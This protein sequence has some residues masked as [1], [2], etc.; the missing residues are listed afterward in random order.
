MRK[1]IL[2]I[3]L[4]ILLLICYK[5]NFL[6]YKNATNIDTNNVNATDI[7]EIQTN[8]QFKIDTPHSPLILLQTSQN[9][10]KGISVKTENSNNNRIILSACIANTIPNILC[11]NIENNIEPNKEYLLKLSYNKNKQLVVTI[12]GSQKLD[13]KTLSFVPEISKIIYPENQQ[14]LSLS[15][16]NEDISVKKLT[17]LGNI[18][19]GTQYR[20][21]I[22]EIIY[23]LLILMVLIIPATIVGTK[24][25][26]KIL[27]ISNLNKF[28]IIACSFFIG[29]TFAISSYLLIATESK[30]SFMAF[31][32]TLCILV[33]L[34][35]KDIVS[36]I[37]EKNKTINYKIIFSFIC[38]FVVIFFIRMYEFRE[39]IP[40]VWGFAGSLHSGR[41]VNIATFIFNNNVIPSISQNFGQSILTVMT[42]YMGSLNPY[43]ILNLW[44]TTIS[45]MLVFLV[46]GFIGLYTKSLRNKIAGTIVILFTHPA[47]SLTFMLVWDSGSP[48]IYNVYSDS[49][50][51]LA[52]ILIF[53]L[54]LQNSNKTFSIIHSILFIFSLS[55]YWVV[56][57][58]QTLIL[59]ICGLLGMIFIYYLSKLL[60]K[61]KTNKLQN[62]LNVTQIVI[63]NKKYL[64]IIFIIFTGS[65]LFSHYNFGM[66]MSAD[67]PKNNIEGTMQAPASLTLDIGHMIHRLPEWTGY[68]F[69]SITKNAIVNSKPYNIIWDIESSLWDSFRLMF[70][71]WV[72]TILMFFYL[73]KTK[74][75]K[76]NLTTMPNEN[77]VLTTVSIE[78]I[79]ILF[80]FSS[81]IFVTSFI[82]S[83]IFSPKWELTRFLYIGIF[84]TSILLIIAVIKLGFD[85]KYLTWFIFV[86]III[87]T[88]H[89]SIT[90][91]SI[92]IGNF[93][94]YINNI[95]SV[96]YYFLRY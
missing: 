89:F 46:F 52:T 74:S 30:N 69:S 80:I 66:L 59:C 26:K 41:Y 10:E 34:S 68:R 84:L 87:P 24:I 4:V 39:I 20:I 33:I 63:I 37:K 76:Q 91:F 48:V 94:V 83:F 93:N 67:I 73:Y 82:L 43:L 32:I 47:L 65:L 54:F 90:R 22:C 14:G 42:M 7:F 58:P 79:K 35:A 5:T 62:I 36:Y 11:Y 78:K 1:I 81:I 38:L 61:I 50:M 56:G 71:S 19:V 3:S 72:G 27:E 17:F 6:L 77:G 60:R 29:L 2:P 12:N 95:V 25:L 45:T 13:I 16:V 88:I 53:I 92:V 85:K 75:E 23:M 51:S 64:L 28:S 15:V 55:F 96:T 9:I 8:L 44:L 57:C 18:L 49:L 31:W 70:F 40:T 86:I 21:A